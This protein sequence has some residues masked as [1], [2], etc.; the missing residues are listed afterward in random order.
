MFWRFVVLVIVVSRPAVADE[1]L[2]PEACV[3]VRQCKRHD[4]EWQERRLGRFA[5]QSLVD[6]GMDSYA[7]TPDVEK[8]ARVDA[9]LRF[10]IRRFR[11]PATPP[12][13]TMV[14][15]I[16]LLGG[17]GLAY[18]S[19]GHLRWRADVTV[20]NSWQAVARPTPRQVFAS[21]PYRFDVTM[22]VLGG[23]GEASNRV[24]LQLAGAVAGWG[25]YVRAG[26]D[27]GG[28]MQ[29]SGGTLGFGYEANTLTFAK[30]TG[31]GTV[32][33]VIGYGASLVVG[34]AVTW[35]AAHNRC[36]RCSVFE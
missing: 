24:E 20:S 12:A 32:G 19:D 13:T 7:N 35:L 23:L 26:Y 1:D 34:A 4:E 30:W 31:R 18:A 6:L 28:P 36:S 27:L 3:R 22:A 25:V 33:A 11:G 14:S 5:W 17:S 8:T 21:V 16:A 29:P 9:I 10:G 15:G 2:E